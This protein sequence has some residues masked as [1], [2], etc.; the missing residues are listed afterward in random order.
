MKHK[1]RCPTKS[2]PPEN[3]PPLENLPGNI[4]PRDEISSPQRRNFPPLEEEF[5]RKSTPT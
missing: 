2:S 5:S 1:K 3:P 4:A